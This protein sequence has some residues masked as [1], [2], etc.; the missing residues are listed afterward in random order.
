MIYQPEPEFSEQARKAKF[1]GY[2]VL[3]IEIGTDGL[4]HNLRIVESPG[5]G[6]EEKA[7]EAVQ[8]WR[9]RPAMRGNTPI[10]RTARV[11]VFFH[12]F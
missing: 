2:V 7:I 3:M 12:I 1:Q 6:L 10:L 9:F 5:L 11:E 4:A 8:R